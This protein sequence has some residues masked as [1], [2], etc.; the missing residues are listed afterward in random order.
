MSTFATLSRCVNPD[1][2][3]LSVKVSH[4]RIIPWSQNPLDISVNPT[5][6][7]AMN[8][9]NPDRDVYER[10][11]RLEERINTMQAKSES[12][13]DRNNAAFERLRADMAQRDKQLIFAMIAIVALG[14]TIFGFVTA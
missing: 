4:G 1:R 2:R 7:G 6:L 14:F 10:I 11:A 13:L 9:G 12:A 3:K 5:T 8:T